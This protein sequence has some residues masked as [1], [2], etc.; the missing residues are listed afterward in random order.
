MSLLRLRQYLYFDWWDS[1]YA[2]ISS[3][4][5]EAM[6]MQTLLAWRATNRGNYMNVCKE[7]RGS[8][9]QLLSDFVPSPAALLLLLTRTHALLSGELAICYIL[10]DASLEPRSLE[11][12]VGSVWFD[13]F[14]DSF[15]TSSE[16]SGYQL[17]WWLTTHVDRHVET[18]HV[19]NSLHIPLS[20]GGSII[21][22]AAASTSPCHAI[23]CSPSSLGTTFITEYSFA[24]AYPRLTFSRRAIVCWDLL[25][26]GSPH[27]QLMYD[28]LRTNGFSFEEDPT[29]WPEYSSEW[30]SNYAHP[31]LACLRSTYLCPQQGRYFGDRGSM[32][33]FM[34]TLAV[35]FAML[36]DRCIPPYGIMAA[37]RLPSNLVCYA[38]CNDFDDLLAPGILVTSIKFEN[39]S[40]RPT[41]RQDNM[42]RKHTNAS[43]SIGHSGRIRSVTL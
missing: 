16:L 27:E 35:D 43:V 40:F 23:A 11:I 29:V 14:I 19:T 36:K 42:P 37:W 5:I 7:L 24:T 21:I 39:E 32:V 41:V 31:H 26:E 2:G 38:Q 25:A 10:R 1:T 12:F 28:R 22:H 17:D 33:C 18:R 15:G 3:S 34:D 4:I 20:T 8:L 13:E 6:D 9:E 30:C